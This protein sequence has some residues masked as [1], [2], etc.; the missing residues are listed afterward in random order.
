MVQEAQD[1][2]I[3]I[4]PLP[5]WGSVPFWRQLVRHHTLVVPLE[6][7]QRQSFRNRYAI[8]GPNGAQTLTIPLAAFS[9][10][11]T[12]FTVKP[13]AN[14]PWARQHF[15]ALETTYGSA[16]YWDSLA[17]ELQDLYRLQPHGLYHFNL[18]AMLWICHNL[19]LN[20]RVVLADQPESWTPIAGSPLTP[21]PQ[22]FDDRHGF[23]SDLCILDLLF[24]LGREATSYLLND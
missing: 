7:A 6:T 3:L 23:R 9:A 20:I 14:S 24:N 18:K 4:H 5:C 12:M 10:D 13:Q 8:D 16:P 17:A 22:V 21:W 11:E 15:K 2:K 1:E 19:D